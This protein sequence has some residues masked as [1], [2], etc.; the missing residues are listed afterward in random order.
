MMPYD[1]SIVQTHMMLKATDLGLGSCWVCQFKRENAVEIF[2]LPENAVPF[3]LLFVGY[4]SNKATPHKWH[5]D[6]VNIDD[7]VTYL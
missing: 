7:Y 6:S 3:S 4:A 2:N 5:Y 1:V